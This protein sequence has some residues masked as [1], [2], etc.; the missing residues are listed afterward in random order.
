MNSKYN[1]ILCMDKNQIISFKSTINL[2]VNLYIWYITIMNN[3]I[4]L[5]SNGYYLGVDLQ[6]IN[7]IA[8]EIMKIFTY[9]KKNINEYIIYYKNKNNALTKIGIEMIIQKEKSNSN[10]QIFKIIDCYNQIN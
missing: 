3:E 10:E 8:E 9:E 2:D 5:F 7:V 4:T 6:H 1:S